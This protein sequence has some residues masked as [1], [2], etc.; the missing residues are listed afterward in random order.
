MCVP[1]VWARVYF[2]RVCEK[3]KVKRKTKSVN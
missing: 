1:A 2:C 3:Y